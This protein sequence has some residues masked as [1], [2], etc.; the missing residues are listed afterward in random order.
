MAIVEQSIDVDVPLGQVRESWQRFTEWVLVGNY[1][2][3][4][5]E[6]SCERMADGEAV[7]FGDLGDGRSRV[8]VNFEFEDGSSADPAAKSR[9]VSTRLTQDLLRFR[10]YAA[11]DLNRGGP[12]RDGRRTRDAGSDRTGRLRLTP[13]S[14]IERDHDDTFGSPH[15]QA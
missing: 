15:Y 11:D 10:E 13:D 6:W 3:L 7:R 9:L 14:L 4:C 12:S 1:R 8:T 5:D 2:L